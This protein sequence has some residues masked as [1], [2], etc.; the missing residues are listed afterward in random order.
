MGGAFDGQ[1][2]GTMSGRDGSTMRVNAATIR[3]DEMTRGRCNERTTRGDATNSRR[4][5]KTGG[6][7]DERTRGLRNDRRLKNQLARQEDKKVV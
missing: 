2:C 5:E 6:R 3:H 1:E 4:G 7:R